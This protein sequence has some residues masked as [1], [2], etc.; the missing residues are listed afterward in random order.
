[1][2]FAGPFFTADTA[3]A[4]LALVRAAGFDDALLR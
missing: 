4:T 1:V 3:D 2:I